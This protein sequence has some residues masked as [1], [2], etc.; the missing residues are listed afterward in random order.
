MSPSSLLTV[1][2]LSRPQCAPVQGTILAAQ[3]DTSQNSE[4]LTGDQDLT[5]DRARAILV[6]WLGS[7]C[8][9]RVAAV[10][11]RTEPP[12]YEM[13][14]APE[15]ARVR[16][17]WMVRFRASLGVAVGAGDGAGQPP[18]PVWNGEALIECGTGVL[19]HTVLRMADSA[20][21]GPMPDAMCYREQLSRNGPE[22]WLGP[23]DHAPVTPLT[24]VLE[25]LGPSGATEL[26]VY[27][28]K[29]I[30]GTHR[31]TSDVWSVMRRGLPPGEIPSRVR[32]DAAKARPEDMEAY[33]FVR[34]AVDDGTATLIGCTN[35]P[36]PKRFS[37]PFCP[38]SAD[39][40]STVDGE[41]KP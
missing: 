32:E 29:R 40:K 38:G 31:R 21:C 20:P 5:L 11:A 10:E 41:H 9:P 8:Q 25:V 14:Y 2:V 23:V 26:D 36:V 37:Q 22:E 3:P 7:G 30:Y 35:S 39:V 19:L 34:C 18:A 13:P 24:K 33:T 17:A 15:S 28:V 1:L 12:H 6:N 4:V 27:P 16:K